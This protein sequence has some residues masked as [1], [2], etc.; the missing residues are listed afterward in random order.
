MKNVNLRMTIAASIIALAAAYLWGC[1]PPPVEARL[2]PCPCGCP[3]MY[4]G[5]PLPAVPMPIPLPGDPPRQTVPEA[6]TGT[7]AREVTR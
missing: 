4:R 3:L 2:T 1:G 5:F 6:L 7:L